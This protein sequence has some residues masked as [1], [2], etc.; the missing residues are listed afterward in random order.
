M[1]N[2]KA[3]QSTSNHF[4]PHFHSIRIAESYKMGRERIMF[5]II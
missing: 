4:Y 1:A 5:M 2:R 3:V